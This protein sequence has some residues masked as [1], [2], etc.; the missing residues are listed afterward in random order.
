M[1]SLATM[2][3]LYQLLT[4]IIKSGEGEYFFLL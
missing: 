4:A 2:S 1:P 3:G